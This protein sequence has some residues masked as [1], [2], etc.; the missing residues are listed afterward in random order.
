MYFLAKIPH[1]NDDVKNKIIGAF[2]KKSLFVIFIF[3][4]KNL[5]I[6]LY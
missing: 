5:N 1:S 6:N 3:L 4:N 2:N